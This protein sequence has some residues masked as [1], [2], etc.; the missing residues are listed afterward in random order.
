MNNAGM[1][2]QLMQMQKQLKKAQKEL[3]REIVTGSAGGGTVQIMLTGTQKFHEV[4]I[5]Q[6][7]MDQTTAPEME[8]LIGSA[9]DDALTKSRKLMAEKLGPLGGGMSGLKA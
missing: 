7:K 3:E 9:L 2:K 8:K 1:M 6:E 4:K 5:E